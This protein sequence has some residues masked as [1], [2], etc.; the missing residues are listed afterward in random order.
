[1]ILEACFRQCTV[2]EG[3]RFASS[4][5][6]QQ[7]NTGSCGASEGLLFFGSVFFKWGKRQNDSRLQHFLD[8]MNEFGHQTHFLTPCCI[9]NDSVSSQ[10]P[11]T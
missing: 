10:E 2:I 4:S 1:M 7:D 5:R 8:R 11:E 3:T 9:S 6:T